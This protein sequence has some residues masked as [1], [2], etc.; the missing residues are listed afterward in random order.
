MKILTKLAPIGVRET[1]REIP[2]LWA[3]DHIVAHHYSR[4]MPKGK[5]RCFGIGR[6]GRL[7]AVAVYGNGVN[8][9]QA[10]YLTRL[11]GLPIDHGNYVELKRLAR[12]DDE[13][14][15]MSWFLARCHRVLKQEKILV[16]IS[17]SDPEQGH[18]GGLYRACNFIHAGKTQAERHCIDSDGNRVHRRRAYRHAKL[19]D[20]TIGEARK[21]LGL[22]TVKTQPKTRWILPLVNRRKVANAISSGKGSRPS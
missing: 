22:T 19:Y 13:G 9:Y 11:T 14:P 7:Y 2:F 6:V 8:P 10:S 1:F 4:S 16:V 20:V 5:N 21:T 18:T 15:P 12:N 3:R 17:F